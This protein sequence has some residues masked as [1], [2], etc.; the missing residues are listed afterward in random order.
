M[1]AVEP[2]SPQPTAVEPVLVSFGD[3]H[4]TEHW[5][6]TPQGTRSL[7]GTQIFVTDMSTQT[8]V[9]PGWAIVLAILGFFFFFLGLLFLLVKET[10]T[11]G[12]IQVTASNGGFTYQSAI[13]VQLDKTAQLFELQSRA[14][15]ARGLIARA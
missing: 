14:N 4:L 6:V 13:P 10:R 5:L 9:T 7:P 12:F 2:L 8:R 1:S 3:I 15:Y 11:T